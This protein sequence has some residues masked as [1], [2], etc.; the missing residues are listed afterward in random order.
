MELVGERIDVGGRRLDVAT[1]GAGRPTVV[2]VPGAGLPMTT[3]GGIP[4]EV[5]AF[6]RVCAY[7][8]DG[9]GRSD[10]GPRPRAAGLIVEDLHA[11]LAGAGIAPPLVL[12]GH[13]FGGL[14]VRL[15]ASR[16]PEDVV[17][18]VLVDAAHE[19][20][21]PPAPPA[22]ATPAEL[23]RWRFLAGANP[24][25]LE[26][27]ASARELREAAP[28]PPVPLAVLSHGR[29]PARPLPGTTVEAMEAQ[30]QHQ[31]R[32]LAGLVPGAL[33]LVAE[34]SGHLIHR[35]QPE[36]VV[37]AIRRIVERARGAARGAG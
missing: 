12:V 25:G 26:Q 36:A 6:T 7:D 32:R 8:R 34:Q 1:A 27:I 35:D 21:Y 20:Q 11:A 31:Q 23:E 5:A 15:Y 19:D 28:L 37:G 16:Y 29:P 10:P 22:G 30:W 13:S 4:A 2:L 24:E 9:L 3:W 18:L 33:H 14:V 17:G